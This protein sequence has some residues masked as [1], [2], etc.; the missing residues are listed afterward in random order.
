[1]DFCQLILQNVVIFQSSKPAQLINTYPSFYVV[2]ILV[3]NMNSKRHV[4]MTRSFKANSI[5]LC[6]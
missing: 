5:S 4:T 2:C 1:L 6:Y 3:E